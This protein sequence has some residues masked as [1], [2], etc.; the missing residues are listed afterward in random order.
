[1]A[2]DNREESYVGGI[3]SSKLW[4]SQPFRDFPVKLIVLASVSF[5]FLVG[6]GSG[7]LWHGA[8]IRDIRETIGP[9]AATTPLS[10]QEQPLYADV[11]NA[12]SD[13]AWEELIPKGRGF[14]EIS[15]SGHK[16]RYCVSVFH[17]LH[18]LDMLRHGCH[19]AGYRRYDYASTGL[20]PRFSQPNPLHHMKHCF[21]YLRQSIM[22]AA[23]PTLE[24]RNESI[25]G[26]TGWGS[27]HQCH[28]FKAL[29]LW[30]ER[31]RYSDEGGIQN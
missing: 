22:C 31:H 18:C 12:A 8:H 13:S 23:D 24:A 4:K 16:G 14:V 10:F 15:V 28:D 9:A 2:S 26:V 21:D 27:I 20:F 5:A 6:F 19:S 30:T 25:G 7:Y 1:M 29:Q 3:D 17:Q 11:P